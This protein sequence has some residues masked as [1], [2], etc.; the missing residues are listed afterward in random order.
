MRQDSNLRFFYSM[1]EINAEEYD[2]GEADG[3]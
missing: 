3:D 2:K 1:Q